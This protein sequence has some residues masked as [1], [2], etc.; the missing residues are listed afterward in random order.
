MRVVAWIYL[1]AVLVA[2]AVIPS[3]PLIAIWLVALTV[4]WGPLAIQW[5]PDV[6]AWWLLL[7]GAANFGLIL[8]FDAL[9]R[10]RRAEVRP[11]L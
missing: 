6:E 8:W 1:V 10:S 5:F 11:Q 9:V 7:A 2:Y 4:P 3:D